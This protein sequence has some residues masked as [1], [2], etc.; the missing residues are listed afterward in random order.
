MRN[1]AYCLRL[2]WNVF[3]G[4]RLHL[5]STSQVEAVVIKTLFLA[6]VKCRSF[7]HPYSIAKAMMVYWSRRDS[8]LRT[9]FFS[10]LAID[11]AQGS[12]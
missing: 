1:A 7:P 10:V 9:T 11:V 5:I 3:V 12:F 4:S 6:L 2:G 8:T